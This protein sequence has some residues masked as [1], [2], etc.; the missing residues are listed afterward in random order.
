[1]NGRFEE[2]FFV[3]KYLSVFFYIRD[4][5]SLFVI[6]IRFGLFLRD[7][8]SFDICISISFG[9]EIGYICISSLE[10]FGNGILGIE[11]NFD[12]IGKVG[13]LEVFV[14]IEIR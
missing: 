10:F 9:E 7:I 11:F 1:M 6:G 13:I 12:F 3:V 2:E 14:G 5:D 8:V 4:S